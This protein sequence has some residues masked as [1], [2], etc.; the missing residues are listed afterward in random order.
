[1][2]RRENTPNLNTPHYLVMVIPAVPDKQFLGVNNSPVVIAILLDP[3]VLVG[4]E[5]HLVLL[6]REGQ[7]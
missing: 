7:R 5:R 6:V 2:M 1:M 3:R 4:G